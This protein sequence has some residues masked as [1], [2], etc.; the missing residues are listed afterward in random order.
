MVMAT[1]DLIVL[2][3]TFIQIQP[4]VCV[5]HGKDI[6]THQRGCEMLVDVHIHHERRSDCNLVNVLSVFGHFLLLQLV[7]PLPLRERSTGVTKRSRRN[8]SREMWENE[9][10][11]RKSRGCAT[12]PLRNRPTGNYA[13]KAVTACV[14]DDARV[15]GIRS[16]GRGGWRT[17]GARTPVARTPRMT[18]SCFWSSQ[19]G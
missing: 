6:K 15:F 9:S 11:S 7:L 17:A 8:G 19:K 5:R 1:L 16:P 18:R 12:S 4:L 14:S 3:R 10:P 13:Q 2:W